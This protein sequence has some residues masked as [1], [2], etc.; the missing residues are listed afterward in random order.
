MKRALVIATLAFAACVQIETFFFA[1]RS[2]DAYRWDEAAP[3]LDGDLSDAH[4]SIVPAADRIEGFVSLDD[5]REVHWVFARR[6]GATT[7]FVYSHGNG[8]HLGRFWDRVERLWELG[9]HVLIYDYPG[10][11]R[12]TG[13]SSEAAL[14]ES[15]DA[16]WE[17][18][19]PSIPEI[20]PE[21]TLLYGHSLGGGPTFH[22]AARAQHASHRPRG[23]IAESVWCSIEAQIQEG[24]FLDLPRELLAHL[25]IDNCA[26]TAEL[27]ASTPITLLQGTEDDVTSPRQSELIESAATRA[28]VTRILVE[29]AHHADLPNVAGDRYRE[30]IDEAVAHAL[31]R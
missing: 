7:T 1:G 24:A 19:V 11:G 30:W 17:Q 4:P 29:G 10:Y 12:S 28:P 21:R 5:E 16:I 27:D 14:Y 20:D 26:R 31:S 8:P 2:I 25:E 6:P 9:H 3:E 13:E 18:V 15:I 22:L 23:V